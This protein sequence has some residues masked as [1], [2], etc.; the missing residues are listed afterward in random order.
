M[1]RQIHGVLFEYGVV[2][3]VGVL[4]IARLPVPLDEPST[5]PSRR[6][7]SIPLRLH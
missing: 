1:S 5:A 7:V 6:L 2:L 3:P 4:P